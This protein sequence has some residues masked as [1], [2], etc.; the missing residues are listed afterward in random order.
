V[1][2]TAAQG[3][4]EIETDAE[5]DESQVTRPSDLGFPSNT[6]TGPIPHH[7]EIEVES[8][9]PSPAEIDQA[10]M[11]EIRMAETIEEFTYGNPHKHYK[12][13]AGKRYRLPV[14][15]ARYLNSLGY[16]YHRG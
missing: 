11:V 8:L 13:E 2:R 5:P 16:L 7:R 15:V 14:D 6:Q 10:G 1:P 9:A 4:I 3:E 12:L